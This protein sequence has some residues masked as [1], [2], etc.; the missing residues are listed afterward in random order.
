[1]DTAITSARYPR[2]EMLLNRACAVIPGGVWG[3]NRFPAVLDP[4]HYPW[5][6]S[7]GKG[8]RFRDV[9]GHSYIDY[10]C[11]YGAMVVGHAHP[12]VDAAA[13]DA[14][15]SGVCLN[16]PIEL[17]VAFAEQMCQL[18]E[19]ADWCA[20][21]KNGSDATWIAV[22]VARA[23]SGRQRL[24]CVEGAYH[25]SQGWCAWCNPG[26]GR[27]IED[28]D[29]VIRVPWNNV[30]ALECALDA[31]WDE[32]AAIVITPFH[33]PIPGPAAMPAP[34]WLDAIHRAREAYGIL[35][36]VDDVRAGFR[37]GLQGSHAFFGIR[38]DIVCFSKAIANGWPLAAVTGRGKFRTAAESVFA[39]GTFWND[40]AGMAA[41]LA[42]IR[43]LKEEN[44]VSRM[45]ALGTR[46]RD[47]LVALS[48]CFGVA[49]EVTGPPAIPTVT[50]QDDTNGT[51]M[52]LFAR[53]MVECGSFVHPSH[54]WF[55]SAAH[56]AHDIDESLHHAR[57]AFAAVVEHGQ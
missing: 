56:T 46:L 30:S 27:L 34:G 15:R 8:A 26:S 36:V 38:A 29:A 1:M 42:T 54:N 4:G 41:A 3:H 35:L 28:A 13:V 20:F 11:G 16:H 47:G 23:Y 52:R 43:I 55:L 33:H 31:H 53:K 37:L 51:L 39:A 40:P 7:E 2:S 6:A 24:I 12:V 14:S 44:G 5:F 18:I 49:L 10:M 57:T 19:G 22:L 25:G 50:I 45:A 32:V 9:D 17:P 48:N 21:G